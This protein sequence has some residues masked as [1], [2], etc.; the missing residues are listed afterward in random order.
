MDRNSHRAPV[1]WHLAQVLRSLAA[2]SVSRSKPFALLPS[3][4]IPERL[5][6]GAVPAV[7]RRPCAVRGAGAVFFVLEV[8][9]V[10]RANIL[11][12]RSRRQPYVGV[13]FSTPGGR[14]VGDLPVLPIVAYTA[15]V[16]PLEVKKDYV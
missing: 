6:L 14:Q 3:L 8:W 13:G 10:L 9:W 4:R 1:R 16:C 15:N 2:W 7:R 11:R 12:L 5:A